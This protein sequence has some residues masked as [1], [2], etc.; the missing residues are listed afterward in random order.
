MPMSV[1]GFS[2]ATTALGL[3]DQLQQQVEGETE[4]QRKRRM[5]QIAQQRLSGMGASPATLALFGGMGA[6]MLSAGR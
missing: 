5:Q 2:P 3:G 4:E 1:P 6:G